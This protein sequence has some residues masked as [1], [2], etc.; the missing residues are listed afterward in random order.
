MWTRLCWVSMRVLAFY[1]RK[2]PHFLDILHM[3]FS[4]VSV[5]LCSSSVHQK[6]HV[7]CGWSDQFANAV[8]RQLISQQRAP[9]AQMALWGFLCVVYCDDP[10]VP[11]TLLFPAEF[12]CSDKSLNIA[13][14]LSHEMKFIYQHL[15]RVSFIMRLPC[16]HTCAPI[17]YVRNCENDVCPTKQDQKDNSHMFKALFTNWDRSSVCVLC[18]VCVCETVKPRAVSL[19]CWDLFNTSLITQRVLWDM[20]HFTSHY[21]QRSEHARD[22]CRSKEISMTEAFSSLDHYLSLASEYIYLRATF[23]VH[24][25][26][27]IWCCVSE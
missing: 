26:F 17:R 14:S 22:S 1:D 19:T 27:L 10:A 24:F 5:D 3:W 9:A 11:E 18:I 2:V 13:R 23:T 21:T 25:I 7:M 20:R 6:P 8:S 16:K 4:H 12:I 15:R